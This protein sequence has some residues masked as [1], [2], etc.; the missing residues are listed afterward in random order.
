MEQE[1]T[2]TRKAKVYPTPQQCG[3]HT[4][5]KTTEILQSAEA[6]SFQLLSNRASVKPLRISN[7]YN[8]SECRHR[9]TCV[10]SSKGKTFEN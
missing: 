6:Q 10:V 5:E 3:N 2:S 9:K 7:D 4:D 8:S 1:D